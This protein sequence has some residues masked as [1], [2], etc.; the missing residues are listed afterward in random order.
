MTADGGEVSVWRAASGAKEQVSGASTIGM[1]DT[2][3]AEAADRDAVIRLERNTRVLVKGGST[4]VLAGQD[5]AVDVVLDDGQ[6]FLDRGQ[7]H[8][9]ASVR[10]LA[11][12]YSFVPTGTAAAVKT[13]RGGAPTVAV[14]RGSVQMQSARGESVEVGPGQF[15]TVGGDGR[16]AAGALNDNGL[17]QLESW[18]GVKVGGESPAADAGSA[19]ADASAPAAEAAPAGAIPVIEQVEHADG[20]GSEGAAQSAQPAEQKP[21]PAKAGAEKRPGAGKQQPTS[22]FSK[23][24]FEL[25]AGVTTVHGR[26][27]TR[28]ALGV[29]MPIWRFGIFLDFEVFIDPDSK[30]SDKGWDFENNAAEAIYRKI[31][32]IR[33]GHEDDPFFVKFG[34]LSS[35][36][37]GYGI[38]MDR[39]TN[40]LRYPDEK[41]LGLQVNL[42]DITPLGI[43]LQT[44]I[45]DFAELGDDGGVVA[46]RL[47]FKPLGRSGLPIIHGLA[48]GGAYA[49]DINTHAPARKWAVGA[50]DAILRDMRNLYGNTNPGVFDEYKG[51]YEKHKGI[52]ADTVLGRLA[53]EDSL[54]RTT[55]SF[56]VYGFDAALPLISTSLLGVTLYGQ[57]AFR[58]DTV[59]GWGI[60]AP[61]VAANVWKLWGNIEYRQIEGK[62]TP[63]YFDRYYLDERYSRGLM[64]EKGEYLPNVSLHGVYGRLGMDVWGIFKVDGSS[65][66]MLVKNGKGDKVQSYEGTA[67]LGNTVLR[68]VPKIN[69]AEVYMRNSNVGRTPKYDKDGYPVPV[70]APRLDDEERLDGASPWQLAGRF[71]RSPYMYWGY[72]AGFEIGAGASLIW[73]YRYGWRIDNGRLVPDNHMF[74]QTALRF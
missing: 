67:G 45:S 46:A 61:G 68:F 39:F 3:F 59:N 15:G 49:V 23:P 48:L 36:T 38:I 62:F 47:T 35:V 12:D 16:M 55:N 18:T 17:Q 11:G 73:D 37:L 8:E 2:L 21:G 44:L 34:G 7:P 58:A 43:S 54:R 53:K 40:M 32:Y 20:D 26:P 70:K 31:R 5:G 13:T 65:Q 60:G 30:V 1:G 22:L 4:V 41:L 63:G 14:L 9:L 66:Y 6:I 29:D 74:L 71:D 27:W 28:L 69:V 42:N 50:D 51:I 64:L 56:S 72:R 33:Y 10:I 25:S 57:S 24:D 19:P 52:S